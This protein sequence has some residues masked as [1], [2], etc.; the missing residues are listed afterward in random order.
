MKLSTKGRY[1]MIALDGSRLWRGQ[2]ALVT[3]SGIAERQGDFAWPIL[4]SSFVKL[5]RAEIVESCART[6]RRLPPGASAPGT[7]PG[8]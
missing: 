8:F 6:R 7:D 5:R 1:A 4:S 2:T 3:L